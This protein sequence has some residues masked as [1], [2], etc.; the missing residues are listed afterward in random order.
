MKDFYA[1]NRERFADVMENASVL[2]IYSGVAPVMRGD[3]YYDYSPQRN[4]L[5]VTGI[6]RAG[7]AFVIQKDKKGEVKTRIYLER[8]DE[9]TAKWDGAAM[10]IE[11]AQEISGIELTGFM[12]E[13]DEHLGGAS[14]GVLVRERFKT[15]YLDLEHRGLD[16]PNT[17]ELNLAA[18]LR[19]KFPAV[20]LVDAHPM[21]AKLRLIK[22]AD[23]VAL[24]QKAADITGEGFYAFMYNVRPNMME[25]EV[26]AHWD[27]IVKMRGTDKSFHTILASGANATV[28]HYNENNSKIN[29]GDLV[30]CD[31]GAQWHYYAADLSRTFPANGKFTPRQRQLYDIVL[32]ANKMVIEACKP[33]LKF[34]ELNDMV[35]KFYAE[36]LKEIG[37]IKE[38]GDV[39]NYYYHGVSHF[40]GLEVH[41]IG[42]GS[43]GVDGEL[44][45]EAG[46][47]ITVEPGLYIAD[48]K[49]GIRIEDDILIT[50]NGCDNLTKNII[51]EAAEIEAYM[52]KARG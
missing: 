29:D 23:E 50:E 32:A 35:K 27:Y 15:V 51:K 3:R 30:L 11:K 34:S 12:D 1:K 16:A 44:I 33:G 25:Y 26:E 45:L 6:D 24:M 8:Y 31:F 7:M 5:Y 2:V 46:M 21:F 40:L 18:R 42:A 20:N 10:T 39:G 19:E 49:I 52:A 48:E 37:L 22:T 13:L 47:V 41:D 43:T 9:H 4:F 36:K 17:P 14:R 38:D 28:L